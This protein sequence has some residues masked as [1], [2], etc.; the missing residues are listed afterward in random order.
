MNFYVR[1][2]SDVLCSFQDPLYAEF[3]SRIQE[4]PEKTVY[5]G[6][7]E[8]P[9]TIQNVEN[10]IHVSYERLVGYFRSNPFVYQKIKV[11]DKKKGNYNGLIVPLNSPLKPILQKGAV[12]L[13]ET[14]AV[15]HLLK[16]WVGRGLPV[17]KESDK[18]VLS[19]G[20][21]FLVFG[22][23]LLTIGTVC[24]ILLCEVANKK[25]TT[26]LRDG[27]FKVKRFKEDMSSL[28]IGFSNKE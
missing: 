19:A 1:Q 18:M 14:G 4:N 7:E 16:S 9:S 15:D 20:Q 17:N 10:V 23:M 27:I 8:G 25:F 21:V 22:I 26:E 11:F 24:C 3:W 13:I 12:N 28:P 5:E 2:K 6:I